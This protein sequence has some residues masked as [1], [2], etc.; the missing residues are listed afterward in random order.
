MRVSRVT[1]PAP[2]VVTG[3]LVVAA[4]RLYLGVHWLTDVTAGAILAAV[5]VTI[6]AA[7]FG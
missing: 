7:A 2:N 3:V 1:S 5:F 4:T 6:G